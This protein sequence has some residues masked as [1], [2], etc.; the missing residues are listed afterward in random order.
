MTTAPRRATKQRA[1]KE[2]TIDATLVIDGTGQT[3]VT[4]GLPFFDHMLD[5]LGRHASFDL[6]VARHAATSTSTRTTPSRT[7]AS[8]W[9]AAWPRRSGTRWGSGASP[10]CWCR[11]TRR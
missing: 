8:S 10:P 5:Q 1:T 3:E 9:A 7:S 11:S 6:S 4:T 2:T